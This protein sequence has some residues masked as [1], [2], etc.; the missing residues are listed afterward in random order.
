MAARA[1]DVGGQQQLEAR[2]GAMQAAGG[3]DARRE[4]EADRAGVDAA[5]VDARDVHEGLQPRLARGGERAQ[6][7][8]D[9]PP[10][11]VH[12]RDE[13]AT[14]ASATRSRSASAAAGS[15][16]AAS[17]SARASR[18]ATPAAHSSGHG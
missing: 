10:V 9:Q 17:S 7:G 15:I 8:A 11:L 14:V 18:C 5:R 4:A 1:R 13:S 3:V 6:A 16:P 12:E 2:V